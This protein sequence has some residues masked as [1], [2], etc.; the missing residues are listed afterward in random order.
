MLVK[1]FIWPLKSPSGASVFF[2]PKKNRGLRLCVNFW[3]LN[4]IT[5]KNKHSLPLVQTLFDL[6]SG[7]WFYTKLDVI[8]A[9]HHLR[10]QKD[11]KWKTA[12]Y[13]R[14]G[15]FEHQVVFFKLVNA[16]AAFQAYVN[17][18]LREYMDIFVLAYLDDIVV[19]FK[20][21]KNHT[22]HI[23]IVLQKLWEFK[24]YIKLSKYVF[25]VAEINFLGFVVNWTEIVIEPLK[26]D[27]VAIWPVSRT[28]RETQ[29]FLESAN[30]YQR[31]IDGF[32]HVA[33]GL[34]DMLKSR[35]KDKFNNKDFVMTTE[36]F[37]AFNK[38]KK[39]FTMAP[40]LMHYKPERQIT[41]K[42]DV[43]TFAISGII[44]QLI[45]MF[46]QWHFVAFW[47]QKMES[48]KC[49]YEVEES[50]ILTI[51]KACKHWH[52]YLERATY[53]VWVVTNH[54]N[55][56]TFLTSKYVLRYKARWWERLLGL[57]LTIKYYLVRRATTL[58]NYFSINSQRQ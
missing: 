40:M 19:F 57:N 7:A 21:H 6:L 52:H 30:F 36:A 42:T 56:C 9:Y 3:G 15:H 26:V 20:R 10:I 58:L 46:G 14:Y 17:Q 16:P 43:S 29:V 28:F 4:V 49:N 53:Q 54:C 44:F 18:V 34:S 48:A 33:S 32:S 24:L 38:L 22:E 50:K 41:L 5:K 45:K 25:N 27:F 35:V 51:V 55:L 2:V 47:S 37:E 1:G 23:Q 11:N 31:F 8:E 12:F 39:C 13:C